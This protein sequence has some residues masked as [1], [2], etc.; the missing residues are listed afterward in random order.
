MQVAAEALASAGDSDII[1]LA[2]PS[3]SDKAA[4]P[5]ILASH[6]SQLWQDPGIKAT[7]EKRAQF[8]LPDS[9]D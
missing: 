2:A 8:Q 7:Y 5:F 9:C 3:S 1:C 6:I 4:V